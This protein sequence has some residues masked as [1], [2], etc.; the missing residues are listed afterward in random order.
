MTTSAVEPI[1]P[2]QTLRRSYVITGTDTGVGKTLFSCALLRAVAQAGLSTA[3]IKPVAAGAVSTPEGLRNDD[4]LQLQAAST[5]QLSYGEVNPICLEL[6]LAPHI[7]AK[8]A[9]RRLSVERITGFC[10]GM[11]MQRADVTVVEGVG[12]WRVPLND[13]ETF[14]DVAKQL[15][16][17]VILVV[18]MRLGCLNHA[19]LTAE[20]I[21][22]DGLTLAGWVANT[23]DPAMP[24][25]AE[26]VET[27]R[28]QLLMAP[29]LADIP[30]LSHPPA[31]EAAA[32]TIDL[33]A[34]GI[35][36]DQ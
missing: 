32:K 30:F 14:A 27:L 10:Q 26:N 6:A 18:G 24:A 31:A 20:A 12:G 22:R 11:L 1:K 21:L 9:G 4:A 17:P 25:R 35:V 5:L 7:A 33:A 29:L 28:E 34:L 8:Q 13:R 19:L 16:L 3:A 2:R 23:V 36:A 15:K